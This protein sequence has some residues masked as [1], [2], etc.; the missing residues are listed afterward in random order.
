MRLRRRNR[1]HERDRIEPRLPRQRRAAAG[2]QPEP[3]PHDHGEAP[4]AVAV[5]AEPPPDAPAVPRLNHAP[6]RHPPKRGGDVA[7]EVV[8]RGPRRSSG[9]EAWARPSPR[10]DWR[11]MVAVPLA[12]ALV[13]VG[14]LAAVLALVDKRRDEGFTVAPL[15]GYEV[16]RGEVADEAGFLAANPANLMDEA[17]A[18]LADHGAAT[19]PGQAAPLVRAS[20]RAALTAAGRWRPWPSRPVVARRAAL[21]CALVTDRQPP[22]MVVSGH[23]EDHSPFRAYFVREQGRLRLD[24]EATSAFSEIPIADLPGATP[25][26]P[27]A[28]RCLLRPRTFYTAS[29]PEE[30]YRCY[31]LENADA[32]CFVWGYAERDSALDRKLDGSLSADSAFMEKKPGERVIVA[33]TAPPQRDSPAQF[34]VTDLL[35]IEWVMPSQAPE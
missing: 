28:I 2:L 24:W 10:I 35:Q 19:S 26:T 21:E 13:L 7:F 11:W 17:T 16:E 27:V 29:L 14:S 32:R 25:H 34:L 23:C 15:L 8:A 6:A 1:N 9:E 30:Q 31:L 5:V 3:A 22:F 33:L 18:I 4:A 12:G 20:Q